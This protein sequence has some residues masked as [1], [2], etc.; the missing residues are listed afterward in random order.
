[1]KLLTRH[2]LTRH[3]LS[4]Y[5]AYIYKELIP[6]D[7]RICNSYHLSQEKERERALLQDI[8]TQNITIYACFPTNSS[9]VS[10]AVSIVALP[11]HVLLIKLLV[12]DDSLTLP[13]YRIMLT[14]T[15][16]GA[17][18][19]FVGSMLTIVALALQLTTESVTCGLLRDVTIFTSTLTVVV[20]SLAVITFAIE[21][22]MICMHFV[23][24]RRLFKKTKITKL[25]YSYWLFGVTIATI[26]AL[27][28]DGKKA[29][30]SI[31]E[32]TSFQIVCSSII[33]PSATIVIIIYS[34]ILLFSRARIIQVAPSSDNS[35]LRTVATFRQKQLRIALVAGVVCIV[36]VVCMVPLSMVFLL[37]LTKVIDNRPDIKKVLICNAMLNTLADPF[38]YGFGMI[39]T[40]QI[41]FRILKSVLPERNNQLRC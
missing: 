14:L 2:L 23:K 11:L 35:K 28:N 40:R 41:L 27:T 16:S 22:M 37:E 12:K 21:R 39:K 33:I 38:I 25:L 34:R 29:E 19:I 6:P 20:S 10:I 4:E 7:C 26:A 8:M 5:F 30:T 36:Y 13:H 17:L 24:Y 1:M 15:L 32:T 3:M 18:Q 31:N 9:I